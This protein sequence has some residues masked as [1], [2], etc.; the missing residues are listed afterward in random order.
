MFGQSFRSD[1]LAYGQFC[2]I[3]GSII[4]RGK[5]NQQDDKIQKAFTLQRIYKSPALV[6]TSVINLTEKWLVS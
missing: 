2:V 4:P 6:D 1:S 5:W 3:E